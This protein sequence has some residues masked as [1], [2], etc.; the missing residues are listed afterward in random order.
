MRWLDGITDLMDMSLSRLRELMMDREAWRPVVHAV[1]NSRCLTYIML[2]SVPS[3]PTFCR[4]R[5]F[6]CLIIIFLNYKW[7]LNFVESFLCI[8]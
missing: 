7:V 5:R 1:A 2:S 4:Q 6:F 3:M 8:N